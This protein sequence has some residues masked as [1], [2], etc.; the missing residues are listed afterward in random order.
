MA[1]VDP[2]KLLTLAQ[3]AERLQWSVK[4]IR[5]RL[6]HHGIATI[7]SGRR[8]RITEADFDRLIEAERQPPRNPTITFPERQASLLAQDVAALAREHPDSRHAS[9][10]RHRIGQLTRR[11]SNRRRKDDGTPQG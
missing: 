7:G 10:L 9:Y 4:T 11:P 6:A 1:L 8:A 3:A 5:R 2:G